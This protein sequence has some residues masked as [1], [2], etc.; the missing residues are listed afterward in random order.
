M[1]EVKAVRNSNWEGT[2]CISHITGCLLCRKGRACD[3]SLTTIHL[4]ADGPGAVCDPCSQKSS[5]APACDSTD[6]PAALSPACQACSYR[7]GRC[8]STNAHC[9]NSLLFPFTHQCAPR[10]SSPPLLSRFIS[11]GFSPVPSPC[12]LLLL[13]HGATM[14]ITAT[15]KE[16]MMLLKSEHSPMYLLALQISI[17]IPPWRGK[18]CQD[19]LNKEV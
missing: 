12:L 6:S 8:S 14:H 16:E 11:C 2:I 1:R 15:I 5:V 19:V 3:A 9:R 13:L 7:T 4:T 18:L 17:F 10:G